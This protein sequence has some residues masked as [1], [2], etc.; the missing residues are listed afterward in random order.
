MKF[1]I[2]YPNNLLVIKYEDLVEGPLEIT[3][4]MLS[5]TKLKYVHQTDTF[6]HNC[7]QKHNNNEYA[8]FKDKSVKD[9]WKDQ[10]NPY[11]IN[12]IFEDLKGTRLERFLE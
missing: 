12:E 6:L 3:K 5:F 8:V 9:K 11:I 10:L 2:E 7:H 1:Q 4:K